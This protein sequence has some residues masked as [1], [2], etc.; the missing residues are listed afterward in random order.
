MKFMK[1]IFNTYDELVTMTLDPTGKYKN[2]SFESLGYIP[3]FVAHGDIVEQGF[4]VGLENQYCMPLYRMEGGSIDEEGLH[5]YPEDPDMIPIV[6][7]ESPKEKCYQYDYGIIAIITKDN[8]V[9]DF[10]TR[11]D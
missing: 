9:P 1:Q 4:K 8:S 2:P 3:E 10:V 5:H 6:I 7:Y 11:M